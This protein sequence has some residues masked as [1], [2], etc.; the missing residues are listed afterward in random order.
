MSITV[1]ATD[2]FSSFVHSFSISAMPK[3]AIILNMDR[4]AYGPHSVAIRISAIYTSP[5]A[6]RISIFFISMSLSRSMSQR[7]R[8]RINSFAKVRF[9]VWYR[10]YLFYYLHRRW[11]CM[12]KMVRLPEL[13][14]GPYVASLELMRKY[15]IFLVVRKPKSLEVGR[16]PQQDQSIG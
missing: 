13:T 10:K 12:Q 6:V 14:I 4:N 2:G 11:R 8:Q 5:V 15:I 16:K 1:V 9:F 7:C 3:A